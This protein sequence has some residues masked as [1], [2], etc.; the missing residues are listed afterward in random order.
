MPEER[1]DQSELLLL[2][3]QWHGVTCDEICIESPQDAD[4]TRSIEALDAAS[5]TTLTLE[6]AEASMTVGGGQGRYVV[7]VRVGDDEEFW[8]LLSEADA[9]G[10]VMI[11]IGGQEGDF[12]ARQVVDH[13]KATR[14]ALCFLE[15]GR[16]D[17]T[18][19]WE[20]QK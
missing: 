8:N 20:L 16:R 14:A 13:E 1:V 19:T 10:V 4:V 7:F 18:L 15:S 5:R 6:R 9:T 2:T 3:D 17:A 11:N 12:P